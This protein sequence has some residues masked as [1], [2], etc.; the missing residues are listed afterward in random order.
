MWRGSEMEK[1]LKGDLEKEKECHTHGRF[2]WKGGSFWT[3]TTAANRRAFTNLYAHT[4]LSHHPASLR[5]RARSTSLAMSPLLQG[6]KTD[7]GI[8]GLN[9]PTV[10]RV[11]ISGVCACCFDPVNAAQLAGEWLMSHWISG[12]WWWWWGENHSW[13]EETGAFNMSTSTIL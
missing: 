12:C 11:L 1:C 7:T 4:P 5:Q 10:C 6:P 3:N 9:T 13:E 2:R 8:I